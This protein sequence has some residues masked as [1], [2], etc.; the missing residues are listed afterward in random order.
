M[1]SVMDHTG[2]YIFLLFDRKV[3][4]GSHLY[5]KEGE[6]YSN[7]QWVSSDLLQPGISMKLDREW[8]TAMVVL[9]FGFPYWVITIRNFHILKKCYFLQFTLLLG[10]TIGLWLQRTCLTLP[11]NP[12]RD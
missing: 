5:L 9:G 12:L 6:F 2:W 10:F 11:Q 8:R 3:F 4:T 1:L 7:N